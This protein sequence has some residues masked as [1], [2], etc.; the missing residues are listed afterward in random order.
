MRDHLRQSQGT[1]HEIPFGVVMPNHVH[2]LL[3]PREIAA[4]TWADLGKIMKL[5]KGG[6]ARRINLALGRNGSVWQDESYDR[7]V[8]DEH[9]FQ[10]KWHYMWE[11]PAR[12][13]LVADPDDYPFFVRGAEQAASDKAWEGYDRLK[14]VPPGDH[15]L[16]N[17]VKSVPPGD[18]HL[19]NEV[20]TALRGMTD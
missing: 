18:H 17:E 7:I 9:E 10:E 12:A 6:G 11:N 15:H 1:T 8:R 4:G 19:E 16:E 14:S 3:R 13:G 20:G 5:V 2:L